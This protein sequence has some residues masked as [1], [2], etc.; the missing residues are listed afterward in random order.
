MKWLDTLIDWLFGQLPKKD[1]RRKEFYDRIY[2]KI[3]RLR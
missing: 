1:P 3:S 2:E